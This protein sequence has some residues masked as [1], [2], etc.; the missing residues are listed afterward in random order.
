MS[1]IDAQVVQSTGH[2]HD[3]IGKAIFGV[4]KYVLDAVRAFHA[5]QGV[6]HD[7]A[8]GGQPTIQGFIDYG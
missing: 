8:R 4:A 1:K 6:F 3:E 2:V 5:G 7:Y